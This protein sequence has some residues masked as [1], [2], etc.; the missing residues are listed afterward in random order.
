M[1]AALLPV[2]AAAGCR[3]VGQNKS[4]DVKL[5]LKRACESSG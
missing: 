4:E 3:N 2:Q 1:H 5:K